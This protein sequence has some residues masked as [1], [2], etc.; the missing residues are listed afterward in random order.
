M[1]NLSNTVSP[2]SPIYLKYICFYV[3]F[4]IECSFFAP[5]D[6]P[7]CP[8]WFL[9]PGRGLKSLHCASLHSYISCD[10][11]SLKANRLVICAP[12]VYAGQEEDKEQANKY[13]GESGDFIAHSY[14]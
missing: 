2:T 12:S 13:L 7:L 11:Q 10:P 8:I 9:P 3:L 6:E 1:S 4:A 5:R 14:T